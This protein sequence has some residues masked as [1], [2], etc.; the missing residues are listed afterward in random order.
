MIRDKVLKGI[1]KQLREIGLEEMKERISKT[2]FD[3]NDVVEALY[4]AFVSGKNIILFGPGG[5]GKSTVVIEFLKQANINQ[6]VI[7][8]YEDMD[9]EGLLGIPNMDKLMNKSIYETAFDRTAF[10]NP[11]IL[12]LEEFLDVNPKT[13]IALKDIITQG[14]LRQGKKF[15]E[16]AIS[17][18]VICSN[19]S[20]YELS[21][22]TSTTAFYKERFPI[23]IR[24]DWKDYSYSR[25][26][27]YIQKVVDPTEFSLHEESYRVLA[28]LAYRTSREDNVVSPRIVK[29]AAEFLKE[30]EYDVKVLMLI[31]GLNTSIIEE[32]RTACV[33]RQE[34]A[35]ITKIK[36]NIDSH[37]EEIL[38]TENMGSRFIID[39]II[40]L[41]VILERLDGLH[42]ENIDT[43]ESF[44]KIKGMC[45]STVEI[46]W[47]KLHPKEEDERVETIT[48][49][50]DV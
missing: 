24:I 45:K 34:E 28:E 10:V 13:A 29:D 26:L 9:V 44:S 12:I 22:D 31:D 33:Y 21:T 46:L 2:F 5:F 20:P 49:I 3:M 15:T 38:G 37:I 40:E 4:R 42:I 23:V 18:I 1:Q 47:N 7:V 50:F 8:G 16:S 27:K 41:K 14:G 32:V 48:K 17:S 25:Y 36:Y 43:M 19:K 35:R 11:G 39:S 6:S 30:N